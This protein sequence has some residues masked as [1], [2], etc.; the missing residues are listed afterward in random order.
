MCTAR[1]S[2]RTTTSPGSSSRSPWAT[3]TIEFPE[4]TISHSSQPCSRWYGHVVDIGPRH[5]STFEGGGRLPIESVTTYLMSRGFGP[6][7]A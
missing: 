3:L 4:T 5:D 1:P 6:D 2:G 7:P